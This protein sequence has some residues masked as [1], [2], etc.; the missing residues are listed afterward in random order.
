LLVLVAAAGWAL[1]LHH[2]S[3]ARPSGASP[4]TPAPSVVDTGFSQAMSVHHQQAVEMAQMLLLGRGASSEVRA[5]ASN[6]ETTQ[7]QEIG[8]MG[9]WLALWN[10]PPVGPGSPMAWMTTNADY[11]CG[12]NHN[13]MPGL[14]NQRELD[15]LSRLGGRQLDVAFLQLM[16]RHHEGGVEM[17]LYAARYARLRQVR[18]LARRIVLDQ[19]QEIT[20]I[21]QLLRNDRAH[22]LPFAMS[23]ALARSDVGP[24]LNNS[25]GS[26][27]QA[28]GLGWGG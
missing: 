9:G 14:A 15:R 21:A 2:S 19:S 24:V 5:L 11:Y 12:L 1:A 27:S 23:P 25:P 18:D 8:W 17:A 28:A 7:L 6:V 20:L 4:A 16:L 26:G 22:P 10:Q 13:V 3:R